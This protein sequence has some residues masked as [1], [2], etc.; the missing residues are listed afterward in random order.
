M[1]EKFPIRFCKVIIPGV[2]PRTNPNSVAFK[3]FK[4]YQSEITEI[5]S[6]MSEMSRVAGKQCNFDSDCYL[7]ENF[8]EQGFCIKFF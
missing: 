8:E 3:N 2:H 1:H 6:P 5:V 4:E 7:K